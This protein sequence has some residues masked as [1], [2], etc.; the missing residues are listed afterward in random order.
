MLVMQYTRP[1][2]DFKLTKQER[3]G[4][5]KNYFD[6]YVEFVGRDPDTLIRKVPRTA[7]SE[8]NDKI[9]GLLLQA[10][11]DLATQGE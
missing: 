4:L 8:L 1:K 6:F 5:L 10:A 3:A 9:G 11:K 2:P 7:F